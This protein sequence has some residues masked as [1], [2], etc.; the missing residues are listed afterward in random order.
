MNVVFYFHFAVPHNMNVTRINQIHPGD[1]I[2]FDRII[3]KHHAIVEDVDY[4]R[5][6]VTI[7]DYGTQEESHVISAAVISSLDMKSKIMRRTLK[8][9]EEKFYKVVH[10]IQLPPCE[11]IRRARSRIGEEAYNLFQ[12]NCEHFAN[13]CKE[14]ESS[15]DQARNWQIGLSV[16]A[17]VGL[18]IRGIIAASNINDAEKK[19]KIRN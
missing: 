6:K 17:G 4:Q 12:S 14:D 9:Y 18:L 1:H 11:V 16:A 13:W 3:Y 10:K 5:E 8:F 2:Y 15:S 19:K 7:I